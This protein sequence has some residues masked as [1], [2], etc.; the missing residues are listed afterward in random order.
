MIKPIQ[1]TYCLGEWAS[2]LFDAPQLQYL[3]ISKHKNQLRFRVTDCAEELCID[4][5]MDRQ[6]VK[7]IAK[8]LQ[9]FLSETS[10]TDSLKKQQ[11]E[12][13]LDEGYS[14]GRGEL[15]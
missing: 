2:T 14:M 9:R 10:S 7:G 12:S 13:C 15:A 4:V 3:E 5:F 6:Q 8:D 1:K 11:C